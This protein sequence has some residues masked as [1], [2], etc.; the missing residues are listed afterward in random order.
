M[1]YAEL[2]VLIAD[3]LHRTDIDNISET[4]IELAEARIY[5]QLRSP[6]M[7]DFQDITFNSDNEPLPTGYVGMRQ[8]LFSG[9][10]SPY[11][12][13]SVGLHALPRFQGSTGTG[14]RPLV[15]ATEG[16][17]ISIAPVG[18]GDVVSLTYYRALPALQSTQTNAML[19]NYPQLFLYG[20]LVEGAVF[21]QDQQLGV[22]YLQL[23]DTELARI[24]VSNEWSRHGEAPTMST[25]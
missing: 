17:R 12:L 16:L 22:A 25:L 10:R 6:E 14:V 7:V 1:N 8:V 21:T 11:A 18:V 15:Y 4:W 19:D 9:A 13:Q 23:F 3:Y 24:T 2:K 20:A 5:R